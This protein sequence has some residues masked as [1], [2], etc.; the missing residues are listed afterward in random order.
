M[1]DTIEEFNITVKSTTLQLETAMMLEICCSPLGS[2]PAKAG[3]AGW[4]DIV[5]LTFLTQGRASTTSFAFCS[6]WIKK[7]LVISS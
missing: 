5:T 1:L 2:S 4:A 6:N 7:T 3:L